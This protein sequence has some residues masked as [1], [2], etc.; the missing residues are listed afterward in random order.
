[1]YYFKYGYEGFTFLPIR[2]NLNYMS[3]KSLHEGSRAAALLVELG[4]K[5]E[6]IH[7]GLARPGL[8]VRFGVSGARRYLDE[9]DRRLQAQ[10]MRRLAQKRL[11]KIKK[12]ADNL[13]VRLT[14]RGLSEY[15][16]QSIVQCEILPKGKFCMVTFDIP[17]SQATL[18]RRLRELLKRSAFIQ[19]QRSVWISNI[20]AAEVLAR[21]FNAEIGRRWIRVFI[22]KE[23]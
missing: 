14:E 5:V 10:A 19:M 18:R 16:Q 15:F 21:L 1:M 3:Q 20:D 13:E 22:A 8:V 6:N 7:F 12:A 9:K 4:N 11:I 17:E 23:Y 2:I